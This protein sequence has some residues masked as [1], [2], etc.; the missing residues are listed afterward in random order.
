M[1]ATTNKPA[2]RILTTGTLIAVKIGN[3]GDIGQYRGKFVTCRVLATRNAYDDNHAYLVEV[4]GNENYICDAYC[5]GP[6]YEATSARV[7]GT[8]IWTR[9]KA[10]ASLGYKH[11]LVQQTA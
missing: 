1:Y 7:I 5:V 8:G 11:A 3:E 4:V 9:E 10:W 2:A 6:R